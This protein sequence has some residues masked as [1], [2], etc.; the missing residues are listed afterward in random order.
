MGKM[1]GG[2]EEEKQKRPRKTPSNVRAGGETRTTGHPAGAGGTSGG[3][4]R[5]ARVCD[6]RVCRREKRRRRVW[7]AT[8]RPWKSV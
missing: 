8:Q 1:R 6:S 4:G 5:C 2:G 7:W 3:T